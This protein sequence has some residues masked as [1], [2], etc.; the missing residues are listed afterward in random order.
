[1]A[2]GLTSAGLVAALPTPFG[3][4]AGAVIILALGAVVVATPW[5]TGTIAA[6]PG[7][8]AALVRYADEPSMLSLVVVAMA[9]L[10]VLVTVLFV[11][12]GA[13]MFPGR[14][15]ARADRGTGRRWRPFETKAQRARFLAFVVVVVL[16]GQAGL[17]NWGAAEADRLANQ[18]AE[19]VRHALDGRSFES[20]RTAELESWFS[21]GP[22]LPG[23]PYRSVV[24]GDDELRATV[25]VRHRLQSRCI[26]VRID[27][28]GEVDL[29]ITHGGC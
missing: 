23:G 24:L 26:R 15:P 10:M 6:I 27:A 25:E 12:A 2:G 21:G 18:R 8:M 16:A 19:Q 29:D 9:P 3:G 14:S 1:M 4:L 17:D 22:G 28:W 20:L 7:V 13:V 11:A 5:R